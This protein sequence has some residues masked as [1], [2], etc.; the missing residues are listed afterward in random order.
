M[1][2]VANRK[3]RGQQGLALIEMVL[4]QMVFVTYAITIFFCLCVASL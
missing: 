2:P 4:L 1:R 3:K